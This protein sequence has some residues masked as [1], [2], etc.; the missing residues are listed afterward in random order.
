MGEVN[1]AFEGSE[2]PIGKDGNIPETHKVTVEIS[3]PKTPNT[4]G[5]GTEFPCTAILLYA[6]GTRMVFPIREPKP[7][8]ATGKINA[9]G[10]GRSFLEDNTPVII[11]INITVLE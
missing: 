10:G 7:S 8:K 11:G 5:R 1:K 9:W 2:K 3:I 6:D 4:D